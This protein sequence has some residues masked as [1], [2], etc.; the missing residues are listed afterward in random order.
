[1]SA[2]V[3]QEYVNLEEDARDQERK[4]MTYQLALAGRDGIVLAS[5]R[6]E[7]H[8]SNT[9][10]AAKNMVG[11][12]FIDH[13]SKYA[14]ACSGSEAAPFFADYVLKGIKALGETFSEDDALRAFE[15]SSLAFV[16]EYAQKHARGPWGCSLLFICGPT[17]RIFKRKHIPPRQE[18]YEGRCVAGA[19]SNL[20]A[21]LPSRFYSSTMSVDE[22][23]WLAAYSVRA[24]HDLD[25]GMIDG[26]DIAVYRDSTRKFQFA[27]SAS[28]WDGVQTFD[29][30]IVKLL[31]KNPIS[32]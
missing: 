16:E 5:D 9:D 27:N 13:T 28:Y 18:V 29:P 1:M 12:I 19:E 26:L 21:F 8:V 32:G 6:C 4:R 20:A 2:A 22:L 11:K 10:H 23:A 7:R 17:K 24:A 30:E 3:S 15:E 14:W 31:K 25:N